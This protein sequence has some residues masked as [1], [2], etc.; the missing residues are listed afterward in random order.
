MAEPC[1]PKCSAMGIFGFVNK[2][3]RPLCD[4]VDYAN[5]RRRTLIV[6]A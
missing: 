2:G 1:A 3:W 5:L 4:I 6:A